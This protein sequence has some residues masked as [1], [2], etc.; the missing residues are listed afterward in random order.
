MSECSRRRIGVLILSVALINMGT[1]VVGHAAVIGTQTYLEATQRDADLGT[2]TAALDRD[3]SSRSAGGHG[4]RPGTGRGA[5][6]TLTDS[7]LRDLST[8][9]EQLPAGGDVLAL[10]GVVFIILIILELVGV[11]DI[12]KREPECARTLDGRPR[13]PVMLVAVIEG[14]ASGGRSH[15][16]ASG[17][18]AVP[19]QIELE[20][21]AILPQREYQCG[22]AALATVLAASGVA[23][24]PDDLTARVYIPERRG[25]LQPE[26]IAATRA[27]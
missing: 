18:A 5:P 20:G 14:C 11:I 13:R 2:V 6:A 27:Y 9:F 25:S 23:V 15:R 19:Q 7:E 21:D 1:P 22:P 10:I 24:T 8:Q 3:G 26:M 4:R 12:F 16:A 17:R